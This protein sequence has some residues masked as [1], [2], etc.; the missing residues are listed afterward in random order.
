MMS[1]SSFKKILEIKLTHEYFETSVSRAIT[2]H[3]DSNTEALSRQFDMRLHHSGDGTYRLFANS[4]SSTEAFLR[5]IK[6]ET[7]S[8][9]FEFYLHISDPNF[10]NFTQI[11]I[12]INPY[13]NYAS[14]VIENTIEGNTV[15]L[16]PN[17]N[18]ERANGEFASIK[19]Y[20]KDILDN[21]V[22]EHLFLIAFKARATYWRYY[23]INSS[24]INLSHPKI[25]GNP[26]VSFNSP[27]HVTVE[28]GQHALEFTTRKALKLSEAPNYKFSLFNGS[29]ETNPSGEDSVT[30]DLIF[31]GL[32][33]PNPANLKFAVENGIQK[34]FSL[35]YLYI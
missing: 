28:N 13:Y 23:I 11:P 2:M 16:S 31:S 1:S 27:Q 12:H 3:F 10:Y 15:L 5:R 24:Q 34:V 4:E 9:Y 29:L 32:P 19:I 8:D 7:S 26:E 25:K 14:D 18:N 33:S 6:T 20:F 17:S 30:S 35:M 21:A 22:V